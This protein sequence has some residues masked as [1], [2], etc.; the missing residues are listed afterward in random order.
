MY[1]IVFYGSLTRSFFL[2]KI[3]FLLMMKKVAHKI[4]SRKGSDEKSLPFLL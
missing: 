1:L 2:K 4:E 3:L